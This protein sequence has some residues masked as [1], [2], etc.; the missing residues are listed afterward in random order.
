MNRWWVVGLVL[1]GAF[2]SAYG[3]AGDDEF[4]AAREAFRTGN[5]ARLEKH[6]AKMKGQLL[7][8]Y[9][10]YWQL[11]MRLEQASPEAARAFLAANRDSPLSER[12]RT[13][14]LKALGRR[15]QWDLFNAELP[16][17]GGDDIEITCY[18]LQSRLRVHPAET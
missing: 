16:L 3:A 15:E 6:A 4:L 12:L 8:S 7:E 5:S 9:V 11:I 14:W 10:S 17:V 13:E 1:A 2:A 18:A